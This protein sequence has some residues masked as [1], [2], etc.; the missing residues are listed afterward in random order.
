MPK[1]VTKE[2]LYLESLDEMVRAVNSAASEEGL[3]RIYQLTLIGHLQLSRFVLLVE[4]HQEWVVKVVSGVGAEFSLP[5]SSKKAMIS[6]TISGEMVPEL[7]SSALDGF[8]YSLPTLRTTVTENGREERVI[9]Q[10]LIGEVDV[11]A[12]DK[13]PNLLKFLTTITHMMT[14]AIYN[15]RLEE[16]EREKR[17]F[18]R[19]LTLAAN[20]QAG[21]YPTELPYSGAVRAFATQRPH[22]SVSG[23]YYDFFEMREGVH[24]F[25]IAD[26]SGKGMPAALLMSNFQAALHTV[27]DHTEDL[28]EIVESVNRITYNNAR[29]DRFVTAFFAL[30]N[31]K[32]KTLTYLNCGHHPPALLMDG[33]VE[34]LSSTATLLGV[35]LPLPE[36]LVPVIDISA[37][38]TILTYTDG[39][40]E[41]FDPEGDEFGMERLSDALGRSDW[42]SLSELNNG[43]MIELDAFRRDVDTH[44]DITLFTVSYQP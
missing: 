28:A 16:S 35:F 30:V 41:A 40:V 43:V 2:D 36:I 20:V 23:D 27:S 3:L 31:S 21:L 33:K 19:E 34:F 14:L 38:M 24:L 32:E 4:E 22:I 6:R 17:A 7:I 37:G 12:F 5:E 26:V 18:E 13:T 25:C 15:R 44:D 1:Q 39:L 10:L 42:K 8:T 11:K 29:G 9:A